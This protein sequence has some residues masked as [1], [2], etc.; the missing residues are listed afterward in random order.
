MYRNWVIESLN[1]DLPY[2]QFLELQL[3][4]DKVRDEYDPDL[5]ALGF[6]TVGGKFEGSA[7]DM[8]A[9]VLRLMGLDHK[10]LTY[11]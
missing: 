11:R 9:T 7:P 6:L 10:K 4:A 5:A 3:A 8:H 1:A 2:D